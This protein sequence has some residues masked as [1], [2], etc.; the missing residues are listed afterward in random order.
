MVH[1]SH[2]GMNMVS[3]NT[4][5]DWRLNNAQ[6]VQSVSRKYPPQHYTATTSLNRWDK[7]GW[8]HAFM[9]FTPNSD[10]NIW[11]QQKPRLIRPGNVFNLLLSSFGESVWIVSSVS[12][13]Y[14]T[15]RHPV[16]SSAAGVHLLQGSMCVCS[17]MVF[18]ILVVT[19]G[20]LSYCC[21]YIISNQSAHSPLTSTRHFIHTT[22][23]HWIFSLFRTILCKP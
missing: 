20:Y 10:P 2:K 15:E 14:L 18:C 19:S 9:F 17:E 3:N 8:I 13:S 23:A 6:L 16:W 12:C 11:M 22:A 1:C 21:L 7:A 4:Q 5:V